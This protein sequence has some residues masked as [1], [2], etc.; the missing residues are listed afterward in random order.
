MDNRARLR[1][2][3]LNF[4]WTNDMGVKVWYGLQSETCAKLSISNKCVLNCAGVYK[5]RHVRG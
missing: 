5:L 2:G 3:V 4:S 1:L